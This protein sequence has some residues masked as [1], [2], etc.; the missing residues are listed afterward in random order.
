MRANYHFNRVYTCFYKKLYKFSHILLTKLILIDY[1]EGVRYLAKIIPVS[2]KESEDNL[3]QEC[4][5]KSSQSG[6][7]KDC[8]KYYLED[9]KKE[10]FLPF[11]PA[12]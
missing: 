7:I 12:K 8:I 4:M 3:Y 11:E 10:K 1:R 6:F 2:F 9:T 5:V